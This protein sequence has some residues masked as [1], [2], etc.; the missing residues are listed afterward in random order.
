MPIVW[1]SKAVRRRKTYKNRIRVE[2]TE[3]W[4]RPDRIEKIS[5]HLFG[6]NRTIWQR[7]G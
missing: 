2:R 5:I 4:M 6:K 7:L 1:K 3:R